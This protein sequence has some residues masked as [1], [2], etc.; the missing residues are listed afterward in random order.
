MSG[1]SVRI[2][3]WLGAALLFGVL[4]ARGASALE[5]D[6]LSP[7]D[8]QNMTPHFATKA[9]PIKPF[10]RPA[11]GVSASNAAA[12]GGGVPG[13]DSLANF[14]GQYFTPGFDPSG[15]PQ[16]AWYYAMV[17][18][19]PELG[20][21]T[22]IDAPI[23]PVSVELLN[24]EG[25]QRYVRGARLFIS[26]NHLVDGVLQ[27]PVFQNFTYS[28]SRTPT[29]YVDAVQ[30]A[31]FHSV[32]EDE[33][34]AW[35]TIL[36]PSVKNGYRIK[37]PYGKYQFSLR[38]DGSCCAFVIVDDPTFSNML[39]PPTY[40]VDNTT[41][42]G[43][44][45]LSGDVTTKTIATLLFS[46]IYLYE[47]GDPTQCCVLGYHTLDFEPGTAA[48]GN[49]PRFY[50][51]NFASWVAP[52]HFR[53]GIQDIV[54]LS[55]EVAEIFNDPFVGFDGVHNVTPW[56]ISPDGKHCQDD[57][58]VGDVVEALPDPT[59]PIT[60]NGFTYHPQTV[61]LL[62]WFEFKKHS[63]AIDGAYSYP[64]VTLLGALSPVEKAGCK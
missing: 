42:L 54:V 52:G 49:L 35:H 22:V 37:I 11:D 30:R 14:T 40:P 44:A 60:L 64:D 63:Q 21:V 16:T 4:G 46:D 15:N 27:S 34:N 57:L 33:D 5:P 50:V 25:E 8:L 6:E 62:E 2:G 59:Y 47:N 38:T 24:A 43:A 3:G 17:G 41:V 28:S 10:G 45:E 12:F 23:I 29:Q 36:K 51:M 31:E 9:A 13:I 56:W 26:S 48:N 1:R 32:L 55:H 53:P 19:S 58:E 61:A 7:A 39:F 18:N 20:G